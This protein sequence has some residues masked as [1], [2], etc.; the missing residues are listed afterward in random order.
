MT[1]V[2]RPDPKNS[3]G[4]E[5]RLEERSVKE[6]RVVPNRQGRNDDPV[7]LASSPSLHY[8]LP[9]SSLSLSYTSKP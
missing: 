6:V 7:L 3:A 4:T 9:L 5:D 2:A 8:S 1:S